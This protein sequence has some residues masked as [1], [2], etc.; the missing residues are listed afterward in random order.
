MKQREIREKRQNAEQNEIPEVLE[1]SITFSE[2]DMAI[3]KLKMRKSPGVIEYLIKRIC[4]NNQ[5]K[6]AANFQ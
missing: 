6:I 5:N 3:S 4:N 1:A 2:L